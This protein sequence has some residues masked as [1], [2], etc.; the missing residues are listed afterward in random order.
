M[1]KEPKQL[2]N[3]WLHPTVSNPE[4]LADLMEAT[5]MVAMPSTRVKGII[6]VDPDDALIKEAL[7]DVCFRA[8]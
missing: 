3:V 1:R 4:L 8:E 6:L 7:G 2:S 5:G